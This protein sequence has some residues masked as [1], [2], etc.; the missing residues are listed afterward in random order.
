VTAGSAG[1]IGFQFAPFAELGRNT[2]Y[3]VEALLAYWS[4]DFFGL[5]LLRAVPQLLHLPILFLAV[6]VTAVISKKIGQSVL[7]FRPT[8]LSFLDCTLALGVA[9]LFMSCVFSTVMVEWWSG[10]YLIPAVVYGAILNARQWPQF[11]FGTFIAGAALFGSLLAANEYA[12]TFRPYL[13]VEPPKASELVHWLE[14]RGLQFG[15][16]QYWTAGPI[17]AVSPSVSPPRT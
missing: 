3:T 9:L 15:Y 2:S 12:V 7:R 6:W 14:D 17:T 10:R 11:S 5:P 8:N 13:R 1:A 16:A 4:A